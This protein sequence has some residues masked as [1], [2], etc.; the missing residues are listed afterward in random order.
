MVFDLLYL[1][2]HSL[3]INWDEHE[4]WAKCWWRIQ[5][6]PQFLPKTVRFWRMLPR[7]S[8]MK[9]LP[10]IAR[11]KWGR[12]GIVYFLW[13][14]FPITCE[15]NKYPQNIHWRESEEIKAPIIN[16]S[17]YHHSMELSQMDFWLSLQWPL[18]YQLWHMFSEYLEL[19]CEMLKN[20]LQVFKIYK[21]LPSMSSFA[22]QPQPQQSGKPWK[23][24][25]PR[26]KWRIFLYSTS[27]WSKLG[28]TRWVLHQIY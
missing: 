5:I 22:Q 17:I 21:S 19:A 3:R 24:L 15:K 13:N 28:N 11:R 27:L 2:L 18:G 9:R 16:W 7:A 14:N 6:F 10:D 25:L 8:S 1:P 23:N 4:L 20:Q 12:E 26:N